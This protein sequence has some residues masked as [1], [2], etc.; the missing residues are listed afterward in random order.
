MTV[1]HP[2]CAETLLGCGLW[3]VL[4]LSPRYYIRFCSD[5]VNKTFVPDGIEM[6]KSREYVEMHQG[7]V[8]CNMYNSH[9]R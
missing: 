3:A 4:P 2:C 9:I 6:L 5:V 8:D 1:L 7:C